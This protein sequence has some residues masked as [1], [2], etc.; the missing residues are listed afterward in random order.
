[1]PQTR[2]E[3]VVMNDDA[4]TEYAAGALSPAKHVILA[5]QSEISDTVAERVAFQEEVAASM[6][7][8][9]RSESLSP[10]FMGNVLAALP[11][12][13]SEKA[14]AVGPSREGLAP[15]SLRHMLG[16]GLKEMKWKS[17][18]PMI[19]LAIAIRKR[20]TVSICLRLKAG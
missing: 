3:D 18:I 7:E 9:G 10:L 17:L 1:M 15:K 8:N 16:H 6:L 5:C 13:E 12:Q 11:P 2:S 19:F 14:G 20:A 4:I